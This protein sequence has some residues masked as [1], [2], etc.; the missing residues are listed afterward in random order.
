[1]LYST[2]EYELKL[3]YEL[4][5]NICFFSVADCFPLHVSCKLIVVSFI[6]L[7]LFVTSVHCYIGVYVI[8]VLIITFKHNKLTGRTYNKSLFT[9]VYVLRVTKPV[10]KTLAR[11]VFCGLVVSFCRDYDELLVSS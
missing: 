1:M 6:I 5:V 8:A 10:K 7:R 11:C 9:E 4:P 3:R 2:I